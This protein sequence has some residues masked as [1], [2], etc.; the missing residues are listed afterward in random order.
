MRILLI[1]PFLFLPGVILANPI[2]DAARGLD[3]NAALV[4][5]FDARDGVR[6]NGHTIQIGDD[7]FRGNWRDRHERLEEG[8]VRVEVE[9][10]GGRPRDVETSVGGREPRLRRQDVDLGHVEPEVAVEFLLELARTARGDVAEEAIFPATIARDVETWPQL[11]EIGRDRDLPSDVREQAIFWL[12]RAAA[13]AAVEG[14]AEIAEDDEEEIEV[15]KSAIFAL[16][17]QESDIAVPRLMRVARGNQHPKV[18]ESAFFWLAQH[19]DP[20][21]LD[22]FE[23]ILTAQ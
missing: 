11:L 4:F 16:S 15:R 13:D 22:L 1:L 19:D 8:P 7:H 2:A 17:Q 9:Y 20:R 3:D 18:R 21:V 6:G 10:R 23:E 14:L 12:G 5:T